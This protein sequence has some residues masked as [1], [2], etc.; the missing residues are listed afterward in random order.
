M[1]KIPCKLKKAKMG[2]GGPYDTGAAAFDAEDSARAVHDVQP[3]MFLG[4][5]SSGPAAVEI[6]K[7]EIR[8]PAGVP[9]C[10]GSMASI[11]YA[12]RTSAAVVSSQKRVA[13]ALLL[14]PLRKMCTGVL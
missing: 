1:R 6:T 4:S 5:P 2:T 9:T 11:I 3:T 14:T 10:S 12:A 13:H 8:R 7:G